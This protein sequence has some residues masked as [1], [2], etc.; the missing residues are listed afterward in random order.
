MQMHRQSL[1][2]YGAPLCETVVEAPQPQGNRSAGAHRALRRLPLRPAHARR[3]FPCSATASNSTCGAAA[4]CRSRSAMRSPAKSKARGRR[5]S[6][7]GRQG[8]GLPLDRLRPMR[9]LQGGRGKHLRGAAPSRHHGRRRFRHARAGPASALSD[10]LRAAFAVL[11]RRADVLGAHRLCGAQAA[12][13]PR[14]ARAAAAGRPRR[15]RLDG[16]GAGARDVRQ[17]ALRRRHRRQEARGGARRRRQARVRSG[18]SE[19]AQGAAESERRYLRGGRFRRLR[20]SR[21]LSPPACWPKAARWW[22][23][24]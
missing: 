6:C 13:R 22:S 20:H 19:C 14:R 2:A 1:T 3:L 5:P 10:R 11:R 21:S 15:R 8:R 12:R 4:R 17:R 16:A 24:A 18:R 9:R 23:P 7:A